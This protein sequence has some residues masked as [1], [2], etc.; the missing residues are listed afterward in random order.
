MTWIVKNGTKNAIEFRDM[1]QVQQL[2]AIFG[3]HLVASN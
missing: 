1:K 3:L 2:S